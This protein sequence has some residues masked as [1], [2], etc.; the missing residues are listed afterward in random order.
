MNKYCF[1]LK[2]ILKVFFVINLIFF[3]TLNAKNLDKF[4]NGSNI[5]D[6]FSGIL[7]LN[8]NRYIQSN[9]FLR[10]LDGLEENH[11]DYPINY[12]YS[13]VNSGKI[14]EAY[15]YSKKLEKKKLNIFESDLI[16]GI[17]YFKR[18]KYDLAEK[19]FSKIEKK[20]LHF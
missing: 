5:S 17:H 4:N 10:N 1:F 11:I 18:K 19:Y 14:N 15:F 8:E 2:F 7:L 13:L 6:Y 20:I 9:R 16:I 12:I 3:S